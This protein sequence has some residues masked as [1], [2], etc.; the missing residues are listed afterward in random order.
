MGAIISIDLFPIDFLILVADG[1]RLVILR[2][3]SPYDSP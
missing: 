1:I 3:K 2:V